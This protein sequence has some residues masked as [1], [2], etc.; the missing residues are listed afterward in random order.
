MTHEASTSA[1]YLFWQMGAWR[2]ELWS[3][4]TAGW[5]V[6]YQ[7]PEAAL[8]RPVS[9]QL[10][11][12]RIAHEWFRWVS[13]D[14]EDLRVPEPSRRRIHDAARFAAVAVAQPISTNRSPSNNPTASARRAQTRAV[15]K[16]RL[17]DA[18][19]NSVPDRNTLSRS[20][21]S[22]IFNIGAS[23]RRSLLPPCVTSEHGHLADSALTHNP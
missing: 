12:A 13:G 15:R 23:L 10:Q 21:T 11:A 1:V 9:N 4:A 5:I 17:L 19:R 20:G 18:R 2:C 14:T 6:L 22:E 3:T 16:C 8:R 7:G